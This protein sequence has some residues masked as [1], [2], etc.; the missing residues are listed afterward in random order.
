[1]GPFGSEIVEATEKF[2]ES[3]RTLVRRAAA[4]P[5]PEY[6]IRAETDTGPV[7]LHQLDGTTAVWTSR[8]RHARRFTDLR[9]ARAA[10]DAAFVPDAVSV[11]VRRLIPAVPCHVR[12]EQFDY[13]VRGAP[14]SEESAFTSAFGRRTVFP[15]RRAAD[16]WIS[17][18]K[19]FGGGCGLRVVPETGGASK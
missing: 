17:K 5:G 7:Y 6:V 18:R 1:M 2:L 9:N 10:R 16:A 14:D 12:T 13:Y 11:A 8:Q 4:A 19:E 3:M 15:C